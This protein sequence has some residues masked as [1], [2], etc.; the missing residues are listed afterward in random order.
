M[1]K[2][3]FILLI[4][5]SSLT[6]SAQ[7]EVLFD[8]A[9]EAYNDG[10][11]QVAVDSY[12][13]IL[14]KG[15]HS[16]ALYYNLGNAHYKLNQIAPSIYYYEKAL[17]LK[18]DDPEVSNNLSYARNM[19]LDAIEELPQTGLS[20][21]YDN[22]IGILTFDQW[23]YVSVVFMILF[24]LLYIAFYYFRYSSRKRSAFV[25]SIVSLILAI[26]AVVFAYLQYNAFK[27]ER[28][29]IVF[30]EETSVKAEPNKKSQEAFALHEGTKVDILDQL[31]DW[32][33]IRIADGT[34]G[35]IPAEDIRPLKD[36]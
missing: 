20:K 10:E 9:T 16:A 34:T 1:K 4:L 33:K 30:A 29:A 31:N 27:D 17:L 3:F 5:V 2:S 12:Q 14:D 22:V 15:R 25:S 7:N 18:P 35:W 19:T 11:Y 36:F 23:A 26:V 24:V 28:P 6:A 21:I 32:Q 13:E 8:R